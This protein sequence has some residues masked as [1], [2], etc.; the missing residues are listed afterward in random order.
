ML[1][2]TQY[3]FYLHNKFTNYDSFRVDP[4]NAF[5]TSYLCTEPEV[6]RTAGEGIYGGYVAESAAVAVSWQLLT[7]HLIFSSALH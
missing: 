7:D 6:L 1:A 4:G 5:E 2:Y 3:L